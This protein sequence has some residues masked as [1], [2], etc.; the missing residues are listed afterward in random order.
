MFD[1]RLQK[2]TLRVIE[3]SPRRAGLDYY[4]RIR[5]STFSSEILDVALEINRWSKSKNK[6]SVIVKSNIHFVSTTSLK[7][8]AN[9]A[10]ISNFFGKNFLQN[11]IVEIGGGW[12]G[13]VVC[14][15]IK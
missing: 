11:P 13:N 9:Y 6:I 3:G 15:I 1:F 5:K 8:G 14:E 12:G 4:R 7:Y 10:N 2:T